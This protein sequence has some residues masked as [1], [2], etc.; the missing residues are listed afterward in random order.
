MFFTSTIRGIIQ[1]GPFPVKSL[2]IWNYYPFAKK[3]SLSDP[4][5]YRGI[6]IS[7]CIGKMFNKIINN[8]LVQFLQKHNVLCKEQTGFIT[9]NRTTDHICIL[10][11]LVDRHTHEDTSH[12]Y[13]CYVD[14][15]RAFDTVS[16]VGL[17]LQTEMYWCK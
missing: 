13:A 16:H 6:T 9:D 3:G 17:F 10:K 15:K 2:V 1:F 5:N 11:N 4:S 12:L 7:S 8:R 14:F